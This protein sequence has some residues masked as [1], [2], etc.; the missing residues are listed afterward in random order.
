MSDIRIVTDLVEGRRLW[1]ECFPRESLTD[2]WEVRAC[3]QQH[4]RRPAHFIVA[5]EGGAITGFLPLSWIEEQQSF[6]YFPGE[7]WNGRTW[8]E[9]NRI[10]VRDEETLKHLL[11]A[12]PGG[13]H[14]RYLLPLDPSFAGPVVDEVNYQFLPGQFDY[15]MESYFR[16]FSH[17]TAKRLRREVAALGERLRWR[18]GEAADF[19]HLVRLNESR[20]GE[21]SYFADRRFLEG[22]R[23]LV[24]LSAERG[25]LRF[26]SLLDGEEP[27]AVDFGCVYQG[28]Y[29][30]LGGGTHGGYPGV[31]KLI[32]LHH[33][34]TG[35]RERFASVDF[36]CGDFAW[37]TLFHLTPQPFYVLTD[38]AAAA[39]GG[40][41]GGSAADGG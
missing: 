19:E 11:G 24:A 5:E 15:D 39:P 31:A 33:M 3:F 22:F 4:F 30:L 41:E 16:Q 21:R 14:V 36:L 37:K 25:W 8:L 6:A 20:F 10:L 29:T 27:V 7:T 13:Y 1:E 17:K 40:A 23:S 35:C 38:E 18:T 26:T 12:C 2:L 9:Q 28:A 34:E 32:N